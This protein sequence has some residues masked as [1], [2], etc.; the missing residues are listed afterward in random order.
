LSY[1]RPELKGQGRS[2]ASQTAWALIGLM[3][4]DE[5]KGFAKLAIQR[6]VSYLLETQRADGT[7]NEPEFTGTGFPGHFYLKYHLYQQHFPLTA[8]GRYRAMFFR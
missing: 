8:L 6:G 5:V 7:W 2:T 1:D 3:A 4:A